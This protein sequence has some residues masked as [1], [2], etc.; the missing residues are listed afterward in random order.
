MPVPELPPGMRLA[1]WICTI[2]R[3]ERLRLGVSEQEMGTSLGVNRRTI[4]RLEQGQT[5]GRD[6]DY[7][8]AG[9]AYVLGLD[10]GR[11]LWRDALDAWRKDGKAPII[12]PIEGP[13]GA[14]AKEL[15]GQS[16]RRGSAELDG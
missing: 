12:G 14:F 13:A 3:R 8:V 4:Q 11:E 1:Y 7:F 5:M 16:L 6:I 15:R 2:L 9:Y 10:D